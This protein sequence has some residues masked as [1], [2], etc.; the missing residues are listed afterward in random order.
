MT[1]THAILLDKQRMPTTPW[2]VAHD[3]N[4]LFAIVDA[5][6][7]C[8]HMHYHLFNAAP[9]ASAHVADHQHRPDLQ[10]RDTYADTLFAF[11]AQFVAR[12]KAKSPRNYISEASRQLQKENAKLAAN[13]FFDV[14]D[15]THAKRSKHEHAAQ[16]V[17]S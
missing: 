13:L 1:H 4:G 16:P 6:A 7:A 8:D 15:H 14:S 17:R 12:I 3:D 2:S 11:E 5:L 10:P 9:A